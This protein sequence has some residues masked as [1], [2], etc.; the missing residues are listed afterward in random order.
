MQN[1]AGEILIL[2]VLF[3]IAAA[4][5]LAMQNPMLF[6]LLAPGEEGY[7]QR[8][9]LDPFQRFQMRM[10]GMIFSFFGLTPLADAL[11]HLF[12][13]RILD[14]ASKGM[15]GLLGFSFIACI[16]I[17]MIFLVIEGIRGRGWELVFGWFARR[18][19]DS[20]LGPIVPSPFPRRRM[21]AES[22]AFTF[23][24]CLLVV[25]SPVFGRLA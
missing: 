8:M 25:L 18:K 10:L 4:G 12:R 6:A 22:A 17:G 15:L 9:L 1:I 11:S 7:Y 13:Y 16:A 23:V 5:F 19:R 24:Y 14:A 2:A 3:G 21:R 20:A